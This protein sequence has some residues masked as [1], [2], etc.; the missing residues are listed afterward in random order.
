LSEPLVIEPSLANLCE[1][2]LHAPTYGGSDPAAAFI[3]YHLLLYLHFFP[4]I[5]IKTTIVENNSLKAIQPI[6]CE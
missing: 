3:I 5:A 2:A 1:Q 6:F 4:K